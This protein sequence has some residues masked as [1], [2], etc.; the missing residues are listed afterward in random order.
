MIRT[1]V[2]TSSKNF[3]W[4]SMQEIIPFI[5]KSWEGYRAGNHSVEVI[6]IDEVNVFK[7]MKDIMNVDNIVCSC[8]T[9]EI[10]RIISTFRK[11]LGLEFKT[12][13][14][15]H[16]QATVGM[17]PFLKWTG[18]DFLTENDYFIVSCHRDIDSLKLA[19]DHPKVL[20]HPFLLNPTYNLDSK[21]EDNR[22]LYIGRVSEQKNL[23]SIILAMKYVEAELRRKQSKFI[24]VGG[25]DD[26]GTPMA[27]V[28]GT[29]YIKYLKNL[30][31]NLKIDDLVEFKGHVDRSNFTDLLKSFNGTFIST[32][33]HSDEN[34][35]V[36]P[37]QF[38]KAGGR[39]ILSDWGGY[40]F[41]R[42]LFD[43]IDYVP[44]NKSSHGHFCL[45]EDIAES[46][47]NSLDK[48]YKIIDKQVELK[49]YMDQIIERAL[50]VYDQESQSVRPTSYAKNILKDREY[51]Y[52]ENVTEDRNH[53][54]QIF[55]NFKDLN[56]HKLTFA[57]GA[58]GEVEFKS[59]RNYF[60]SPVVTFMD[61]QIIINDPHRGHFNVKR[62]EGESFSVSSYL[63]ESIVIT[64]TEAEYL[65]EIG[66]LA[67]FS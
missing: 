17:W 23:H 26:L 53:G 5:T 45:V 2:L 63:N 22:F 67:S 36:A 52:L 18:T 15:V 7:R 19:F 59:N 65:Y 61:D 62:M 43:N 42:E 10:S 4:L 66:Y 9:V 34:F 41:F 57:Y 37:Y 32:S 50:E 25:G 51:Y 44:V 6:D 56:L 29:D 60:I 55:E 30:C 39:A 35:G 16:G 47:K 64:K 12:F 58:K 28:L 54:S 24:V 8:F 21:K 40:G 3:R 33:L 20:V 38:L 48:D 13:F 31:N 1:I 27:G 46:L 14:Y 49:P 11:V